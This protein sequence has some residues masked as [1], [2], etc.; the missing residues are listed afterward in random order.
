MHLGE[1]PEREKTTCEE[2]TIAVGLG[3]EKPS[4]GCWSSNH[5]NKTLMVSPHPLCFHFVIMVR[6]L[7]RGSWDDLKWSGA[8]MVAGFFSVV[9]GLVLTQLLTPCSN[10]WIQHLRMDGDGYDPPSWEPRGKGLVHRLQE[11]SGA[12]LASQGS[13]LSS[14]TWWWKSLGPCHRLMIPILVLLLTV[15][16]LTGREIVVFPEHCN[17]NH[18]AL[19]WHQ[20]NNP[21]ILAIFVI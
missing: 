15:S 12:S 18:V 13:T 11:N 3:P 20:W 1:S 8:G 14:P 4:G 16:S 6:A 9:P 5:C 19:C 2:R 17:W 21:Q 10:T 7:H